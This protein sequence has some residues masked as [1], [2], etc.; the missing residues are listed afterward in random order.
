MIDQVKNLEATLQIESANALAKEAALLRRATAAE[1]KVLVLTAQV[2]DLQAFSA[3]KAKVLAL[4]AQMSDL[5]VASQVAIV[6]SPS[7]PDMSAD[8]DALSTELQS[9]QAFSVAAM[10]RAHDAEQELQLLR[11]EMKRTAAEAPN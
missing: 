10:K 4:S 2:T 8:I 1:A 11:A 6:T 9:A 7:K 3:A 5:R